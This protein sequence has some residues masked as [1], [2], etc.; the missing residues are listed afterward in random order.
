MTSTRRAH[1]GPSG[2]GRKRPEKY[3]E[4][5]P[6]TS[7][8]GPVLIPFIFHGVPGAGGGWIGAVKIQDSRV[9]PAGALIVCLLMILLGEL[10][11]G[12]KTREFLTF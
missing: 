1:G 8:P 9:H 6:L 3:S 12:L 4:P 7:Y 11:A 10:P 5:N 2:A